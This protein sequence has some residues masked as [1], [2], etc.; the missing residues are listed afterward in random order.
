MASYTQQ[1]QRLVEDY[2][3]AG[4]SWPTDLRSVAAWAVNSGLWQPQQSAIIS[5]CADQLARA[6]REE[7][8]K[9]PQGRRVRTKHPA[10]TYQNG[11][12]LVFWDDIRTA[13]R[14]HMRAAFQTR[15]RQIVGDCHQLKTDIDSYNDNYNQ[16][17]PVQMVF[18]FTQDLQELDAATP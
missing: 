15:R 7:Y 13:S 16:A 10:P 1:L 14:D 18:D 5:Q 11:K 6:L 17:Q 9:D 12:Q 4:K 3:Q 8:I 2:I